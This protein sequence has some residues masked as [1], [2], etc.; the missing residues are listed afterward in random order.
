M[1]ALSLLNVGAGRPIK[2]MPLVFVDLAKDTEDQVMVVD[3]YKI[4]Q[5]D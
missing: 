5:P 4:R 2:I 3:G 1:F